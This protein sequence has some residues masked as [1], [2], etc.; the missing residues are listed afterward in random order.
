[1]SLCLCLTA[2]AASCNH[3]GRELRP[4]RP[5]Q[6]ASIS[7][8]A[9]PTVSTAT[10]G[11]D[12]IDTGLDSIETD[13]GSEESPVVPSSLGGSGVFAVTAPWRDTAAIDARYTCDGAD[14]SPPLTWPA[15][16][17][18]IR[19]IAITMTDDQAPGF[20]HWSV[21]GIEATS[22]GI[23]EGSLPPGAFQGVNGAGTIGYSGPCPPNGATHTYVISVHYLADQLELGDG[24]AG[25][26]MAVAIDASTVRV[27]EVTGNFSRA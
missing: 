1:M 23:A 11:L 18:G 13:R 16:P 5:D 24:A 21:G 4:A 14:V 26:D 27:A 12:S 9:A 20:V 25:A 22:T 3:D 7:T 8:T 2:V 19:E 10:T 17:S 15:A 6:N